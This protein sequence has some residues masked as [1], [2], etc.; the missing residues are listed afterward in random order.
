MALTNAQMA[1]VRRF[2]GYPLAGTTQPITA[3]SDVVY[4]VFGVVQ[5]TLYQRLTTMS[6]VEEAVLVNTYLTN[7]PILEAA[8]VGA[9][10]NL[11]TA[12]AA[13]WEWNQNEVDDRTALFN[14]W[15]RMMCGFI[16]LAPGP[17]LGSGG[18]RMVRA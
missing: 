7:L 17:A 4:T 6:S 8:I 18:L 3:T 10:Q 15:R 13:V 2:A 16:G 9:A 5:M 14:K 11:D 12:K 1:D